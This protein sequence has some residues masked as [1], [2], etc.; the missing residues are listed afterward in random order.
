MEP[1]VVLNNLL[2][3]SMRWLNQPRPLRATPTAAVLNNLLHAAKTK[4]VLS[5]ESAYVWELKH[6]P[7]QPLHQL[8]RLAAAL[9]N[10]RNIKPTN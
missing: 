9:H 4:S 10:L 8:L 6:Q 1:L 5:H 2:L 3:E 7:L